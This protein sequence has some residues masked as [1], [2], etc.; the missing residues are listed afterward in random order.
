MDEQLTNFRYPIIFPINITHVR[1]KF[2]IYDT[3][4]VLCKMYVSDNKQVNWLCLWS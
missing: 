3:F 1:V 4:Y 2:I